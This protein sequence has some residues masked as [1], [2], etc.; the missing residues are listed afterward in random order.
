MCL[1]C[2]TM[3]RVC[4]CVH[5]GCAREDFPRPSLPDQALGCSDMECLLL[6]WLFACR[7]CFGRR[8][9]AC[10]ALFMA[11]GLV[12]QQLSGIKGWSS[13]LGVITANPTQ[14]AIVGA[15]LLTSAQASFCHR[16][17]PHLSAVP[18]TRHG[19]SLSCMHCLACRCF[20]AWKFCCLC[21]SHE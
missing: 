18:A 12:S 14:A 16:E 17:M 21:S 6:S 3:V 8:G 11:P 2:A 19:V 15:R 10:H 9:G 7:P 4:V 13:G 5:Q 1:A 20:C